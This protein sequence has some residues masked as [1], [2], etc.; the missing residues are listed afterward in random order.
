MS[1]SV[2]SSNVQVEIKFPFSNEE[3]QS[4]ISEGWGFSEVSHSVFQIQIIDK[5]GD[6]TTDEQVWESIILKAVNGSEL[7]Q[8]VI[9]FIKDSSIEEFE[10]YVDD[11]DVVEVATLDEEYAI[12][13]KKP[14]FLHFANNTGIEFDTE[15]DVCAAQRHYRKSVSLDEMTGE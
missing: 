1:D 13:F 6:F 9:K 4:I 2:L 11:V 3:V 14:W 15:D 8:K 5:D 7:H 12:K 10:S